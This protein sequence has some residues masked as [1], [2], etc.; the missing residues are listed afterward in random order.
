MVEMVLATDMANHGLDLMALEQLVE[1]AEDPESGRVNIDLKHQPTATT[2]L[3]IALHAA[4]ISN[5]AKTWDYYLAWT[6]RVLTEFH[7]Q[8]DVEREMGMPISPGFDRAKNL[9]IKSKAGGQLL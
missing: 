4:D 9:N 2:V 7:A 5:P 1:R 8:G 3:K 6:D